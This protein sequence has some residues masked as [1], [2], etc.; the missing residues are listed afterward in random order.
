MTK[1]AYLEYKLHG[2]VCEAA[3]L[4]L[5]TMGRGEGADCYCYPNHVLRK[6]IEGLSRSYPFM[7][8]DNEAGMEHLSRGTTNNIDELLIVSDYSV[9]GVRTIARIQTLVAELGLNVKRQS[10]IL[11]RA[12]DKMDAAIAVEIARLGIKAAVIIPVDRAV[13][14][15]DLKMKPLL[16]LPGSSLA[17]RAVDGLMSRLLDEKDNVTPDEKEV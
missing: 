2:A 17:V 1:E 9:K 6:I 3:G 4:D 11:N 13:F 15:F 16:D 5:V 10:V 12:P 14:E 7:V 8:L